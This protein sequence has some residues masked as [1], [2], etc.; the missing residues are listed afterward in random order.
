MEPG[1]KSIKGEILK[2]GQECHAIGRDIDTAQVAIGQSVDAVFRAVLP[3][4][5]NANLAQLMASV[6]LL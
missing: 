2:T 3:E 1:D 6:L 4:F 5:T